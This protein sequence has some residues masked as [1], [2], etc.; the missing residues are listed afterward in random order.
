MTALKEDLASGKNVKTHGLMILMYPLS[1]NLVDTR[2]IPTACCIHITDEAESSNCVQ[3]KHLEYI[4]SA[5]I[6]IF[7][8]MRSGRSVVLHKWSKKDRNHTTRWGDLF[9]ELTLKWRVKN[10]KWWSLCPRLQVIIG[11][12]GC[13]IYMYSNIGRI[14]TFLETPLFRLY[15]VI[16]YN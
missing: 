9:P 3:K 8:L 16:S 1:Y 15:V 7:I 14:E 6:L 10:W 13:I 4:W 12:L 5:Y 2:N 11:C